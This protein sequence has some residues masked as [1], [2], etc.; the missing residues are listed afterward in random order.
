MIN[1]K[2]FV[3]YFASAVII[4]AAACSKTERAPEKVYSLQKQ[5]KDISY[6][7]H[8]LQKF[9][10]FFPEGYNKNTP[11]VFLIHGGAF[12]AGLKEEI[13]DV[14]ERFVAKGFVT[15]NL[16]HR[17]VDIS[18][19]D[20]LPPTHKLSTIKVSDQVDDMSL[21]VKKFKSAAAGWGLGITHMYMA[22]HSAGGTLAMLYVQG[23][24]NEGVRAS[25]NLAGLANLTLPEK[26]YDNPPDIEYWPTIKELLYRMGGAEVSKDKALYLMA[27]SP[28]WVTTNNKPGKPNITV[29]AKTNDEDLHFDPYFST[30]KD[31]EDYHK[32]LRSYGTNSA[33]TLMD[34][35]HG[36]G[37]NPDDWA[38]AV[39]YVTEFFIKN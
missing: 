18:G 5:E 8:P 29:M 28:N 12:V 20:K 13:N 7:N 26:I 16:N 14:A 37:K 32:Q 3:F 39:T 11:V 30:I 38:K 4:L 36:F 34:T 2:N 22:G 10:I 15:V 25:G 17:L 31:A 23:E 33:Y 1:M 19:L 9:D 21:A 24:K 27:I 35:D 6:G